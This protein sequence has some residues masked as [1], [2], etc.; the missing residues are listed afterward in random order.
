MGAP[1]A[2]LEGEVAFTSLLQ[3]F[4]KLRPALPHA[5]LHWTYRLVLRSVV[6][7][8]VLVR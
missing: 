3:R 8:P 2:R 5:Q 6:S 1:L 7:L 4:P